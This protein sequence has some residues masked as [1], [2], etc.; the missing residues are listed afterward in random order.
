MR[1]EAAS[2]AAMQFGITLI[3]RDDETTP[4]VSPANGVGRLAGIVGLDA[5]TGNAHT[6]SIVTSAT[7]KAARLRT[8][9]IQAGPGRRELLACTAA[10]PAPRSRKVRL[11]TFAAIR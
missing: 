5:A 11:H 4:L 2:R 9:V 10:R 8:A 3:K 7:T 1:L 6:A